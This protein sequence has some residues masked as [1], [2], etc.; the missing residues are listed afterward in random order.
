MSIGIA[1]AMDAARL[2]RVSRARRHA[3]PRR[4]AWGIGIAALLIFVVTGG[5]RIVGSDEVT[6]FELSR[7]LLHGRIAVSEGATLRGPDG[8]FYS[9]NAAGQAIA[10]LPL[11]AI[12]EGVTRAAGVPGS[13]AVLAMRFG[14]SFFNALIA[15]ILREPIHESHVAYRAAVYTRGRGSSMPKEELAEARFREP[16]QRPAAQ[17]PSA[18]ASSEPVSCAASF[19][20]VMSHVR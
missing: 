4:T 11:T 1:S 13:R 5:G 15:A 9:K 8:R 17:G 20:G 14:V 19:C 7:G 12:A 18:P 3:S 10:A 6:M 2:A 16:R